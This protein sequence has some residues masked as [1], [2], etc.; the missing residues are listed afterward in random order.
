MNLTVYQGEVLGIGGLV[1]S[2][3]T[4]LA[5][6]VCGADPLKG[7]VIKVSG[8]AR[9]I[10]NTR[11]AIDA[12]LGYLSE[13]RKED[14]LSLGLKI[15]ENT[16]H[17]DMTAVS[18]RGF[19]NWKRVR[20]VSDNYIKM[21]KTKGTS[22]TQVVNL[23]GG[24]QQKVVI[25]KWLYSN[26]DVYIFDEPTRG[27]DVGARDEIYNIMYDL[28]NQG[29]SIIMISSDLVEV[30]KMCD[31]VAVM[32]EGVLEAILDNSPDLTQET[33]LKYAMQGGI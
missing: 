5:R 1:G 17:C 25:A 22:A 2:K 31:R 29:A 3:R 32:R 15:E 6:M 19:M 18:R 8:K 28:V 16:I 13:N 12:G 11:Q 7:G 21:L 4:E 10:T 14:G 33:I 30:L 27:I 9:R 24:N 26:A 20:E 23:S